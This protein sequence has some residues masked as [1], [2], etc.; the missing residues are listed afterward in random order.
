MCKKEGCVGKNNNKYGG[1][2]YK[3]R[4]EYLV[5]V[6]T[7]RI[8]LE[9]WTDKCSDYLKS[10]IITSI[11]YIT[12]KL[13]IDQGCSTW[14]KKD[15][16]HLLSDEIEKFNKYSVDDI[17]NIKKIQVMFKNKRNDFIKNLRGEGY[18]DKDKCNNDTDFFTYDG[19]NDIE[20]KYFFSY[21]DIH[22][23]VWF[24]DIRLP[25][26]IWSASLKATDASLAIFPMLLT[27]SWNR[28]VFVRLCLRK[29]FSVS[30]VLRVCP[31]SAST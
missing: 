9:H 20:D 19:I 17:K 3:H 6:S 28:V 29:I 24:F 1:F 16:F 27:L 31:V 23:N 2:C 5:D 10:D 30:M 11:L 8:K 18:I 4:R 13:P 21:K 25:S 26:L 15:L 14:D 7:K 22:N 12:K